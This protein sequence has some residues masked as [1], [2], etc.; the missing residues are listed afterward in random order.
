MVSDFKSVARLRLGY[1]SEQEFA[2]AQAAIDYA[3]ENLQP[4]VHLTGTSY[5]VADTLHLGYGVSAFHS[6]QVIGRMG[7][8]FAAG[9]PETRILASFVDRPVVNI[10]GGRNSGIDKVYIQGSTSLA[11]QGGSSLATRAAKATYVPAGAADF[12][13][14]PFCGVCI[15]AYLGTPAPSNPYPTPDYPA[16]LGVVAGAYNRNA[17]SASF[18]TDSLI[19]DTFIG[20]MQQPYDDSNGDFTRL[21]NLVLRAQYICIAIGN[22]QARS[23]DC[24]NVRGSTFH[25][26]IDATKYGHGVG[27]IGGNLSNIHIDDFYQIFN[28]PGDW[29]VPFLVSNLYSEVGMRIGDISG[30]ICKFTGCLFDTLDVKNSGASITEEYAPS[31][32]SGS[33]D[34]DACRFYNRRYLW[35]FENECTFNN[36]TFSPKPDGPAPTGA[37]LEA[38]WGVLGGVVNQPASF[39]DRFA[40]ESRF[41]NCVVRGPS[42]A[43][44]FDGYDSDTNVN[45]WAIGQNP[46]FPIKYDFPHVARIAS[47]SIAG[48]ALGAAATAAGHTLT[49][50][51]NQA[52]FEAGD[53][54]YDQGLR[55]WYCSAVAGAG[56]YTVTLKALTGYRSPNGTNFH[57]I[58]RNTTTNEWADSTEVLTTALYYIPRGFRDF[59]PRSDLF[60]KT[61]AASATLEIVDGAGAAANLPAGPTTKSKPLWYGPSTTNA[62]GRIPFPSKTYVTAVNAQDLTMSANALVSGVWAYGPGIARIS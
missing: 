42:A 38:A 1:L 57:L 16:Y 47:E 4:V 35:H 24:T 43:Y 12:E 14:S 10:Q 41:R 9:A 18:I 53:V 46:H 59:L 49:L 25:T 36:C 20:V 6:I 31:V 17:S 50:T 29:S 26:F 11:Y 45:L 21:T 62:K 2:S 56:P 23:M 48:S 13:N 34:F 22:S 32:M 27:N 61:T 15:D 39:N 5:P 37:L 33:A 51:M 40:G 60:F 3:L 30:A 52:Y 58:K 7:Y 54:F 19:S 28:I 44:T 8:G 55:W